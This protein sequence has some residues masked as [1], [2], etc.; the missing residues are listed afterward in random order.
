MKALVIRKPGQAEVES[1]AEPVVPEGDLLLKVRLVGFCGS[2]LN[3]FRGRNPLVSFPRIPGHEIAGIIDA[4]GAGVAGW[5]VG[6]RVGV[7]RRR[8]CHETG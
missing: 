5:E 8:L 4:V 6:Q 2:D 3:S 7:G 1:V